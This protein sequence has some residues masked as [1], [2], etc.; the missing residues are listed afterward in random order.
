MFLVFLVFGLV[1]KYLDSM[2]DMFSLQGLLIYIVLVPGL[3]KIESDVYFR[4]VGYFQ[5]LLCLLFLR[6]LIGDLRI[7]NDV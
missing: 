5:V 7:K 2:V 6:L 1:L 4:I 3:V